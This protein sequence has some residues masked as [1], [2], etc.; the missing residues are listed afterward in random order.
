MRGASA[1]GCLRSA[2][3]PKS[4]RT[5]LHRL[6]TL[7]QDPSPEAAALRPRAMPLIAE[8]PTRVPEHI[9]S[10]PD[11]PLDAHVRAR[12]FGEC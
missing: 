8:D 3:R 4:A 6:R 9:F 12:F 7:F 10:G 2:D 5:N 11:L 1:L